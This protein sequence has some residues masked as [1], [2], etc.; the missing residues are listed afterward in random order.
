MPKIAVA[1]VHGV[2]QQ[3]TDFADK[4]IARVTARFCEVL[5]GYTDSPADELVM[6][7]VCWAPVLQDKE[8][9]LWDKLRRDG[10]AHPL[11]RHGVVSFV[12]DGIAYQPATKGRDTYNEIHAVVG[13]HLAR[14]AARAGD[15]ALLCFAG[16][17][18]G[19]IIAS[20]FIYDLQQHLTTAAVRTA[21]GDTP[22]GRG[23][24]LASLYTFGCPLALWSLRHDDFGTPV[25]IPSTALRAS[26]P[27]AA[28]HAEWVNFYYSGDVCGYPLK[29][30]NDAYEH[31][32]KEDYQVGVGTLIDWSAWSHMLYWTDSEVTDR[33]GAGLAELWLGARGV[34]RAADTTQPV[35]LLAPP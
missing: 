18:L 32:V 17:S 14:L 23:E 22:L 19:S 35:T 15:E 33:I 25:A 1:V 27:A 24:T 11:V 16:H 31:A 26:C 5:D 7:G 8:N 30:L 10:L 2:G 34:A 20:N 21:C 3:G 12:A 28:A 4:F 29:G 9:V 13:Q 6:D